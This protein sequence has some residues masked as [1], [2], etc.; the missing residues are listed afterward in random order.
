M[1]TSDKPIDCTCACGATTFTTSAA[2]LFRLICHCTICQRF[3]DAAY[4]DVAVFRAKDVDTP[5][6]GSVRYERMRRP[7]NVQRGSCASCGAAAIE[8][9]HTPLMPSLTMV[10]VQNFG[11]A[12]TLPEPAAHIF[13]ET[14][15]CDATDD[16]P[17]YEGYW[18]SQLLFGRL[19]MKSLLGG[20]RQRSSRT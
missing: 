7:P 6:E 15:V 20:G 8:L 16:L 13:Y 17:K 18:S 14:R 5:A 19:L 9:F 1:S 2:P 10:P 12:E 4:G 3:N 11:A